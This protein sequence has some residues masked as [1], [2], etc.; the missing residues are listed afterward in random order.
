MIDCN[1]KALAHQDNDRW[2]FERVLVPK[3]FNWVA[4]RPE[5]N[6]VLTLVART[7]DYRWLLDRVWLVLRSA[8]CRVSW[9]TSTKNWRGSGSGAI[10]SRR[11]IPKRRRQSYGKQSSILKQIIGVGVEAGRFRMGQVLTPQRQATM[12]Q[13]S[14][15]DAVSSLMSKEAMRAAA[16]DDYCAGDRQLL[17]CAASVR[18][19]DCR[20]VEDV[21]AAGLSDRKLTC[22]LLAEQYFVEPSP[23]PGPR[24]RLVAA[25]RKAFFNSWWTQGVQ[26]ATPLGRIPEGLQELSQRLADH[27]EK[28]GDE[29]ERLYHLVL[30][31]PD[32]AADVFVTEFDRAEGQFDLTQCRG[33]VNLLDERRGERPGLFSDQLSAELDLR[34]Q[35]LTT[36]SRWE[37]EYYQTVPYLL[38]QRLSGVLPEL[39]S[40]GPRWVLHMHARGGMG[41]T[42]FI[43]YAITRHCIPE[44][45]PVAHIDFDFAPHQTGVVAEAHRLLTLTAQ[46]L[47]DQIPNYPYREFLVQYEYIRPWT[48][49]PCGPTPGSMV[50]MTED[51]K[52][53][54]IESFLAPLSET[55]VGPL[56]IL[57][58]LELLS[59]RTEALQHF[60]KLLRR[61][62]EEHDGLRVI[63]AGR[64]DL[65]RLE[66]ED[67]VPVAAEARDPDV[68]RHS[69]FTHAFWG[70][71]R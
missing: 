61:L 65:R 54:L 43:R 59:H 6:I 36:R 39:L 51:E 67:E 15:L 8:G 45:I 34:R 50:T 47:N 23:G 64:H 12:L 9:P 68:D 21:L 31:D 16:L 29:S 4:G 38:P 19:F 62:H 71:A 58:T 22:D 53:K 41:K 49:G 5:H 35:R 40:D 24:Y 27:F 25:Y 14:A 26:E 56:L 63:L 11:S 70:A 30:A 17:R 42:M 37:H 66:L 10:C 2:S 13:N 48:S 60:Y 7:Q 69:V 18:S 44:R 1:G 3:L 57:D 52:E 28:L 46:Q 33:L 20:L 55:R 32:A